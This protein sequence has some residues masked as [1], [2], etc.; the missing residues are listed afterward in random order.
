MNSLANSVPVFFE[1]IC[2][3]MGQKKGKEEREGERGTIQME[4]RRNGGAGEEKEKAEFRLSSLAA[5]LLHLGA[6][7]W[8]RRRRCR[9]AHSSNA[10]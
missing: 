9:V 8:P 10:E 3:Q 6:G 5:I 1:I 7:R 2:M 4:R